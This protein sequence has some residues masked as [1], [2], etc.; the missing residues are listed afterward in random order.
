MP[1]SKVSSPWTL[2]VYR[3]FSMAVWEEGNLTMKQK[4]KVLEKLKQ[5]GYEITWQAMR[6]H[7]QKY[8]RDEKAAAQQN[9][10][11]EQ[12]DTGASKPE[13]EAEVKAKAPTRTRTRAPKRKLKTQT[14]DGDDEGEKQKTPKKRAKKV[15]SNTKTEDDKPA[16]SPEDD[17]WSE[18]DSLFE[19]FIRNASKT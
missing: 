6:Q 17:D 13:A 2:E 9:P 4:N 12:S 8:I 19:P 7:F 11:P 1:K 14:S 15:N 18:P 16:S 10:S 5:R 3:D